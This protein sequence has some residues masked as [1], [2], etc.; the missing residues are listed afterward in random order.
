MRV[1]GSM[2]RGARTIRR[3]AGEPLGRAVAREPVDDPVAVAERD[4]GRVRVL[5]VEED[6]HLGR[7]SRLEAPPEVLRDDD[8]E[9][10][11]AAPQVS[12]DPL[13]RIADSLHDE[14]LVVRE[15]ID[16]PPARARS[17]AVDHEHADVLDVEG[18]RVAENEELQERHEENDAQH[19]RVPEDLPELLAHEMEDALHALPPFVPSFRLNRF[20]ARIMRTKPMPPSAA[21]CGQRSASTFPLSMTPRTMTR[22]CVAGSM[23]ETSWSARGIEATGNMNPESMMVGS[24]VSMSESIMATCCVETS[25]EM[26][27]PRASAREEIEK[28]V[29]HEG[30]ERAHEGHLEPEVPD[31]HDDHR[32]REGEHEIRERLPRDHLE[33]ANR[34]HEDL[35]HRPRFLLARDRDGREQRPEHHHDDRDEPRHDVVRRIERAVV[36]DDRPRGDDG[37]A[38]RPGRVAPSAPERARRDERLEIVLHDRGAVRVAPVDDDPDRGAALA[39][40]RSREIPGNDHARADEAPLEEP[41]RFA[42]ILVAGDD[43]EVAR[44]VDRLDERAALRR[45]AQIADAEADVLQV[46]IDRVAEEEHH[47]VREHEDDPERTRVAEDVPELLPRE[48]RYARSFHAPLTS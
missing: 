43:G 17:V 29:E 36:E 38:G 7:R 26:R 2:K 18:H 15:A 32:D 37:A 4:P 10:R 8:R 16:E 44:C 20:T 41:L 1:S 22:K 25:V 45:A 27:I 9:H 46:E 42:R 3:Q 28:T 13:S 14:M 31:R 5:P 12:L 34:A 30:G 48:R 35:L 19:H 39:L 47:H 11:L 33:R 6:L 24:S 23:F 21:T 40:E